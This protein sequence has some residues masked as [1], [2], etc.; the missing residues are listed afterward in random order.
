MLN[1][2][3]VESN[4]QSKTINKNDINKNFDENF[5]FF[6]LES[7]INN[8]QNETENLINDFQRQSSDILERDKIL[9][10]NSEKLQKLQQKC[11]D[12]EKQINNTTQ[13][14]QCVDNL[15]N[16]TENQLKYVTPDIEDINI[17]NYDL[18][19]LQIYGKLFF[20]K[21]F[22]DEKCEDTNDMKKQLDDLMKLSEKTNPIASILKYHFV[23][24]E[25]IEKSIKDLENDVEKFEKLVQNYKNM[26]NRKC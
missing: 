9:I 13:L 14:M 24:L 23:L 22:I 17:R 18:N 26:Q 20:I 10:N 7:L 12:I 21:K 4:S 3:G 8:L 16:V 1:F 6:D 11:N 25:N 19:R 5:T 2:C 15:I